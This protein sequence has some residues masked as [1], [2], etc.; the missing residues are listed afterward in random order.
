MKVKN[1]VIFC[2]TFVILCMI[3]F[4]THGAIKLTDNFS[5][6]GFVKLDA[7]FQDGG[8]NSIVAARYATAGEGNTALTAMNTR[9]GFKWN[10]AELASGWKIAAQTEWDLFDGASAN[11][12]KLRTRHLN[13]TLSKDS[14]KFLF[15]QFW[16]VFGPIGPTTLNTNGYLW[17]TGNIGFR[18]AQ[19]RYTYSS[20]SFNFAV[21]V[22]DPTSAEARATN[23]PILQGRLGLNLGAKGKIKI[24]VSGA[25][26][27]ESHDGVV[28]VDEIETTYENDVNIMGVCLD[29]TIPF[30]KFTFKGEFT[31]GQNLK[32]FLSKARIYDNAAV[33][34]IEAA[35]VTAFWAELVY[36][37]SKKFNA[38]AGYAFES[39][40]EEQL[41]NGALD[42]T[43]CIFVGIKYI[44][45]SGVSFG[46]EYTNFISKHLNTDDQKTNQFCLSCIYAF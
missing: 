5:I 36:K 38:W 40:D 22:N 13:F 18:R 29:W 34:E 17:Q 30:S 11:Q 27:S 9:V 3:P 45:G 15:G 4:N 44:M 25:Y 10:V 2:T 26:G 39:L 42:D 32:N 35:Q 19:I 23:M 41:S 7:H 8:M 33:M 6:Y 14:S 12:M 24:G 1:L 31:V 37:A 46:L 20:G 43:N 21:S 28:V 16:D